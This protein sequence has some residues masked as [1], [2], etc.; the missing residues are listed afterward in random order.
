MPSTSKPSWAQW[1]EAQ[2]F[3]FR[4]EGAHSDTQQQFEEWDFVQGPLLQRMVVYR[5]SSGDFAQ[6]VL[7]TKCS[8]FKGVLTMYDV[9]TLYVEAPARPEDLEPWLTSQ[10]HQLAVSGP[11]SFFSNPALAEPYV[12]SRRPVKVKPALAFPA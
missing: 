10:R 1:L 2:G 3:Y 7:R 11:E 8:P 4:C 12:N 5:Q 6:A 9:E